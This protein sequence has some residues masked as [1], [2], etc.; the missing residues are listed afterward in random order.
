MKLIT[1]DGQQSY[2]PLDFSYGPSL[3]F[4]NGD[5]AA[6]AGGS[7]AFVTGLGLPTDSSQVQLTVGGQSA[8]IVS[9]KNAFYYG[10]SWPYAYPYPAVELQVTLPPGSG[11]QDLVVTTSSGS[12]TLPK[13]IHYTQSVKDYASPDTFQSILLD[14]SRNQLYLSAGDHVDVFSLTTSQFLIPFKPPSLNGQANF[15]GLAL[16]TGSSLLLAWARHIEGG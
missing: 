14:R 1:P 5:T 12:S 7:V 11:D 13:A 10:V 9:A 8:G 6:P 4:V 16:T 2:N 3:M 15:H